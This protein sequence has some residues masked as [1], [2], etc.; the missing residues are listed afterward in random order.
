MA[1]QMMEYHITTREGVPVVRR[2][3]GVADS[4]GDVQRD[5]DGGRRNE[6]DETAA[7]AEQVAYGCQQWWSRYPLQE[8]GMH[9]MGYAT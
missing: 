6:N 9:L 4:L 1:T 3:L 7:D 8:H 2:R 5:D